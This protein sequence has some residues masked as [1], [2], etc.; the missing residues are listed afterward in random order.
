VNGFRFQQETTGV[1]FAIRID[2]AIGITE[3]I[4]NGEEVDGI[5][6]GERALLGVSIS[7][8]SRFGFGGGS[9][10]DGAYVEGVGE[11]TPAADAGIQEGD[12]IVAIGDETIGSSGDLQDVMNGYHPGDKVSVSWVD[13]SGETRHATVEL[14]EGP[15]A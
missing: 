11:D 9:F 13:G 15:P 12:T 7:D 5:H 3:Q 4:R 10:G 1:G 14:V 8:D 6:I 2:K